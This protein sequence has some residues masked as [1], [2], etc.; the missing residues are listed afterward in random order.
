MGGRGR[1]GERGC[2]CVCREHSADRPG[3]TRK[4]KPAYFVICSRTTYSFM[5]NHLCLLLSPPCRIKAWHPPVSHQ[6]FLRG[7]GVE[8]GYH[9]PLDASPGVLA[10]FRPWSEVWTCGGAGE[11]QW[12]CKHGGYT[13]ALSIPGDVAATASRSRRW[14]GGTAAG[15]ASVLPRPA[16]PSRLSS[17]P[18]KSGHCAPHPASDSAPISPLSFSASWGRSLRAALSLGRGR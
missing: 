3:G 11:V 7:S 2:G 12:L 9:R 8:R 6:E 17:A 14:R 10:A 4:A 18:C 15:R 5:V 13:P 1:L 16:S